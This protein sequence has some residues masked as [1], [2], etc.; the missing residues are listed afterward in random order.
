VQALDTAAFRAALAADAV[1]AEARPA[2]PP[3]LWTGAKC[4]APQLGS[5]RT[6]PGSTVAYPRGD[7]VARS[8]A[9]RLVAMA[10]APDVVARALDPSQ[11]A[12]ALGAGTDRAYIV[13]LPRRALVPCREM[14]GWPQI[15]FPFALVDTRPRVVL[16]EGVPPLEI[17]YDGALRPLAAP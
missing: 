7:D 14:A 5:I 6:M 12:A 17:E 13:P 10:N 9:A 3:F 2:L 8:L 4:D 16:R 1:H 11:F 15:A